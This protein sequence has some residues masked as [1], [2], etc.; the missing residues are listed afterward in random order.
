MMLHEFIR[1]V[2]ELLGETAMFV[3]LFILLLVG[4]R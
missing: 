3:V 1:A 2:T 4:L